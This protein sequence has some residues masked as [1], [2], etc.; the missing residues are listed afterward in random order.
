MRPIALDMHGFASFREPAR[1]EFG[2][3]DFFALVGPTGSGKSTVIDAMTFALYGSVPRWGRKGMVSL[4]LAPTVARGTVKLVFEVDGQRYVAARELRR[5]GSRVT[6]RAASLERLVSPTGLA[7]PGENTVPLAKDVDSVTDTVE[8][9]LGLS[10]EDFIQCVVLPQGQFADFLHAK[11]G[12]RQEIL[13][14]LLGAEHYKQMMMKANQRAADAGQ[15]AGVLADTLLGYADATDEALAAAVEAEAALRRLGDKVA[16]ALPRIRE[17]QAKL[18]VADETLRGLRAEHAALSGLRVPGDAAALDADLARDRAALA[19]LRTG[20]QK[21]EG[22]EAAARSALANGPRRA[23]LELARER[24]AE[25]DGLVTSVPGLTKDAGRRQRRAGEAADAVERAAAH[26][27]TLRGQRDDAA[28]AAESLTERVRQLREEHAALSSVPVPDGIAALDSKRSAARSALAEAGGALESAE[29]ADSDARRARAEAVPHPPLLQT[30]SDLEHLRDSLAGLADGTR[31]VAEAREGQTAAD[32][33]VAAAEERLSR[34]RDALEEA[35]RAHVIAGLRPHLVAGE[36][37]P[38]CEQTVATLPAA[39]GP[40]PEAAAA[41]AGVDEAERAV[42]RARSIAKA[43]SGKTARAETALESAAS[44]GNG[45]LESL[46]TTLSGPL[47]AAPL[48]TT[49]RLTARRLTPDAMHEAAAGGDLAVDSPAGLADRAR[50]EV[51]TLLTKLEELD[52]AAARADQAANAARAAHRTAQARAEQAEAALADAR[53]ALQ[54]AR[55][56]LVRFGA[57]AAEDAASLAHAWTALSEWAAKQA[58]ERAAALT[59]AEEAA[60]AGDAEHATRSKAFGEAERVLA[61]KRDEAKTAAADEQQARARLAHTKSRVAELDTLLDG[62][63][64][65]DEITEQLALLDR[66]QAEAAQ[67]GETLQQA[68]A[69]RA[70]GESELSA[71]EKEEHAARARLSAARDRVVALGAPA[72]DGGTG[73]LD[74]WTALVTWAEGQAKARERDIEAAVASADTARR[75]IEAR[76]GQLAGDLAAA[77]ITVDGDAAEVADGAQAAVAA[78]RERA[79]AAVHRVEERRAEAAGFAARQREAQEE[80]RVAKL[81]GDLLRADHFQRWLVG[82]ALDDLVTHASAT[83]AALSS[84]Q[85]DLAYDDG[86]F[87]VIDH[88]DADAR[89]SVRT[90]SGGETFQASLALALALSSQITALAA[91]GAARLDSI[92]LDEGF[93]TLD[94]ETLDVVATTLETLAQGDRMVGVVTHVGALAERVPVRFRVSRNPR[95]STVTRDG[96]DADADAEALV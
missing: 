82:A 4:A 11:P 17:G 94:P 24:R 59:Q 37:C 91:A 27:E 48:E 42:N 66:L 50:A 81:L 46:A 84:G 56:P 22:A 36:A 58:R 21:A 52:R 65:D 71:R 16:A 63:P 90:L 20:E 28:R 41:R 88:A 2:D 57:P 34:R 61:G 64:A 53:N 75:D 93:G 70:K 73:L 3:A 18:T 35:R 51:G 26:L 69:A 89:R 79:K 74:G 80:Q 38:L 40:A 14:R 68:R 43:A 60:R 5:V 49:R 19:S 62:A 77:G 92:F 33:D 25:R 7:E 95:T 30:A 10:Y 1:V 87:Y 47:Q 78:E 9:L 76:T 96:L 29:Q 85:F 12:D 6:Q 31:A 55:D 54:A 15:R 45:L 13:L 23:P 8:R 67:A 86:D 83:L 44:R 39:T 32:A 72:L